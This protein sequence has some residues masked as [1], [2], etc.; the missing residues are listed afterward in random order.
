M[1]K[2]IPRTAEPRVMPYGAW[3]T[4]ARLYGLGFSSQHIQAI[5]RA[6]Q[7]VGCSHLGVDG[8]PPPADGLT[9]MGAGLLSLSV[10]SHVREGAAANARTATTI[11]VI[12]PTGTAKAIHRASS[13][14]AETRKCLHR[15]DAASAFLTPGCYNARGAIVRDHRRPR[16]RVV[17]KE[18]P[19]Q[20]W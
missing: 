20:K 9:V 8:A 5:R 19:L 7:L 18:D 4:D 13:A 1:R 14:S 2:A 11:N 12:V 10:V 15:P 17:P 16:P 3:L 6:S